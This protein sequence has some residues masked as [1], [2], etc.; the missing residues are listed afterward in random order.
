VFKNKRNEI[1]TN[2]EKLPSWSC[3]SDMTQARGIGL[4]VDGDGSGAVLVIQPNS[5][6]RRD[7]IVPL[8]FKGERNIIIP[9]GEAAWADARWGWRMDTKGSQYGGLKKVS[10]AI[11]KVP[12]K[13]SVDIK[14]SNLR[15]LPEIPTA[16]IN[17]IINVNSGSMHITGKVAS[18]SFLWFQGGDTVGVYDLNWHKIAD[19]PVKKQNFI[20]PKGTV[21]LSLACQDANPTPWLE[22]Q[23]F[24]KDTPL[25]L[26]AKK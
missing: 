7:Y 5:R 14:V 23:F 8:D 13:T 6:G 12:P 19:L 10:L 15:V 2:D 20:A 21:K 1:I 18:E 17:P 4:T 22:W 3:D 16:V 24:V 9:C 25:F 26:G 11:G